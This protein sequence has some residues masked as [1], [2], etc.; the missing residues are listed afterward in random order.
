MQ[1]YLQDAQEMKVEVNKFKLDKE[2]MCHLSG[3]LRSDLQGT[4][5][6]FMLFLLKKTMVILPDPYLGRR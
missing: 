2:R 1:K 3:L 5:L 6:Y 4:F